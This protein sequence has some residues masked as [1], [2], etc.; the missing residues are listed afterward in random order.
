MPVH[1]ESIP[2]HW[3]HI[4]VFRLCPLVFCVTHVTET[5]GAFQS[6]G[7]GDQT[8]YQVFFFYP[9]THHTDQD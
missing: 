6:V 5:P 1:L 3:C 7:L 9:F 4:T 2:T 8:S